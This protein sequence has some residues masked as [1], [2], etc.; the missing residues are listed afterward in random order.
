MHERQ[1]SGAGPSDYS[2]FSSQLA[3]IPALAL[4]GTRLPLRTLQKP[5]LVLALG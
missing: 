5:L 4:S 3:R 2:P 1:R